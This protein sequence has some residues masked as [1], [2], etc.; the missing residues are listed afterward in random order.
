[1]PTNTKTIVSRRKM[2]LEL[3]LQF[4]ERH[5]VFTTYKMSDG[6]IDD[7][8]ADVVPQDKA[9]VYTKPCQLPPNI[10]FKLEKWTLTESKFKKNQVT[11]QITVQM[12]DF[13]NLLIYP[14]GKF[15]NVPNDK[16]SKIN[17]AIKNGEDWFL[18][19][20]NWTSVDRVPIDILPLSKKREQNL[21]TF[22]YT[23]HEIVKLDAEG[24]MMIPG[25]KNE[26][27]PSKKFKR[28]F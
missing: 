5:S 12:D 7:I 14:G 16:V 10:A 4:S 9:T 2:L 13:V 25:K 3:N 18:V 23:V 19:A 28:E 1:M 21:P 20:R 24:N 22:D 6:N 26:G 8:L 17:N 11:S 15:E 27:S